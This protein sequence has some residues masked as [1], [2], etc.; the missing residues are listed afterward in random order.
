MANVGNSAELHFGQRGY[1]GLNRIAR[2]KVNV[3]LVVPSERA[4]TA[5]GRVEDF[6]LETLAEFRGLRER[7]MAG[8]IVRPVLV[9]GPFAAWSRCIAAPGSL[10]VGDAADFFDPVT[11]DGIFSALRGAELVAETM[12]PA[13]GKPGP[14]PL[15]ALKQYR[16]LRR[17]VFAAK[18]LMERVTQYLMYFPWFFDRSVS[19]M[20]RHE[21]MAHTAIGVAGGFVPL[22]ELLSPA[23]IARM[24]I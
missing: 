21:D 8:E 3:A 6:F 18:W 2:D 9:T 15:D 1:A 19:R 14:I 22:R 23:F 11:G 13:M 10:L 16:R 12:V 20:G 4:A 5:R 24:V 7:V 17:Q